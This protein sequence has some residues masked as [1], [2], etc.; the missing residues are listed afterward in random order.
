MM[1]ALTMTT[2]IEA[3]KSL[4]QN[5]LINEGVLDRIILE[6]ALTA[7]D[8]VVE[9]GPG[10]GALTRRLAATGAR[11]IAVEKDRRLIEPLQEQFADNPKV[12][13]I[14]GDI[15]AFDPSAHGL[16]PGSYLV[17]ANIPYYLTSR[18]LRQM[19]SVWPAPR[20]AVLM[21][22]HE[23]AQRMMATPPDM[24]LLALSVQLYAVPSVVMRVRRGS[25]RPMPTV[26]S[27]VIHLRV[28]PDTDRAAAERVLALAK[29]VFAHKRKQLKATIAPEALIASRINPSAR[30][31]ELGPE[32]WQRVVTN[33]L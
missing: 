21:V 22:Q 30:P 25:F 13:I 17:V 7:A 10:R 5:F 8:T 18:L 2:K 26:D 19:L 23:V 32:D 20:S 28:K 9:V 24:N 33:L 29:R 1:N 14:E 3:K 31:Q 11:V 16:A 4:G 27:V 12:S 6:A 15:L